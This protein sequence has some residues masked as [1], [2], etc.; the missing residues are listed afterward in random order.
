VG[1]L[2]ARLVADRSALARDRG[3]PVP[4]AD[5]DEVLGIAL[6]HE[7]GRLP[8]A[9]DAYRATAEAELA[10]AAGTP[11]PDLWRTAVGL[12]E[13]VGDAWP[14]AYSRFRLAE[15]LCASG[16]QPAAAEPLTAAVRS[17]RALGARPLLDDAVALARR[18]RLRVEDDER[19]AVPV[20]AGEPATPFGLTGREREVL[21]LVAAGRSNGQIATELYISRKTASVHVSN[22]LAKLGVAGRVEAAAVAHRQGLAHPAGSAG[23]G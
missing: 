16:E 2:A 15:V 18:A 14:L 11:R 23:T 13:R 5:R 17:A 9:P 7:E 19:P 10:R 12:W 1:W 21:T 3:E 22:I 8:P 6:A 4:S 20:P